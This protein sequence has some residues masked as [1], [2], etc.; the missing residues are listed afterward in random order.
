MFLFCLLNLFFIV[1]VAIA[2]SDCEV[3]IWILKT[4][5]FQYM[6]SSSDWLKP[7]FIQSEALPRSYVLYHPIYIVNQDLM[8]VKFYST[9]ML[10]KLINP[11]N[12]P[13]LTKFV[14]WHGTA[15]LGS[16]WKSIVGTT[17]NPHQCLGRTERVWKFCIRCS[18]VI[19]RGKQW[20]PS[21]NVE[22]FFQSSTHV[23]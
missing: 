21:R 4:R 3:P 12:L 18:D 15:K 23:A 16:A 11:E 14:L 8:D 9:N 22:C 5:V 6:G 17:G 19:W 7:C 10:P 20:W 2:L 1:I 13:F